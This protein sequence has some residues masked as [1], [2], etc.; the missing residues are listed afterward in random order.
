MFRIDKD[1]VAAQLLRF[2]KYVEG[3]GGLSRRL[4]PVNFCYPSPR[5]AADPERRIEGN[6][7]GGNPFKAGD[8][9]IFAEAHDGTLPELLIDLPNGEIERFVFLTFFF[10][11]H[12]NRSPFSVHVS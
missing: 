3:Q 1:A 10:G 4:R 12:S 6:G 7:P 9:A 11:A 8:N 5:H 2:S